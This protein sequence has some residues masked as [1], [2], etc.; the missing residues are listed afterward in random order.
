MLKKTFKLKSFEIKNVFDKK[1]TSFKIIREDFFD[2]KIFSINI[3]K[4]TLFS[5]K[6]A[7]I[8]SS[9][10]F[11]KAVERNKIKRRIYSI[12]EKYNKENIK[13]KNVIVIIYPKLKIKDIKFL[14]LE[15]EVYNTLNNTI[16]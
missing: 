7:V 14:I 16:K 6:Y 15:K 9:K 11:K 4:E 10:N 5:F 12:L 8:M 1:N 13:R 2:M 3:E